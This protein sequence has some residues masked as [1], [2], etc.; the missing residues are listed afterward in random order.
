MTV[1]IA[2]KVGTTGP[3]SDLDARPIWVAADGTRYHVA[4]GDALALG[5]DEPII[6]PDNPAPLPVAGASVVLIVVPSQ[7]RSTLDAL[8]LVSG[9]LV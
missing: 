6:D 9:D 7:G 1:L 8:G 4:N 3:L 2:Q 5:V